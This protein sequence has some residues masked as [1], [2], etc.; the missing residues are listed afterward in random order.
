MNKM[1]QYRLSPEQLSGLS[2]SHVVPISSTLNEPPKEQALHP[3]AAQAF[4]DLQKAA[5]KAGFTLAAA[6]TFR[7]FVRQ[8]AIWNGKFHGE[9]KVHDDEGRAIDVLALS[10][11]ERC[12]AIMRWSALPAASRHH[13]G[14][15]IDVYDPTLLP[16]GQALQL[17]P[18]EYQA[19]GY[20]APLS[21]WLQQHAPQF[22][23]R[24]CF[25][26]LPAPYRIGEEPWHLSFS[27]L[28]EPFAQQLTPEFLQK[29]WRSTGEQNLSIVGEKVLCEHLPDIFQQYILSSTLNP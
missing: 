26:H 2:R 4:H 16:Q 7:D 15:E 19:G 13:W 18:W 5:Q 10:E 20:F 21:E 25:Q 29:I 11:W 9:R 8:R 28:A 6:S 23:F 27:E 14:T 22:G 1:Q 24:F 3:I 12:Q 17:E